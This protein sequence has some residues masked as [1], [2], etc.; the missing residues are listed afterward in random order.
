MDS[1]L[2]GKGGFMD[3]KLDM[4]K[5]YDQVEW[6]FLEAVMRKMGFAE[7]WIQLLMQCVK[8]VSYSILI[9]GQPH[10]SITPSRGIRQGD[11]LSP[12]LFIICTEAMSSLLQKEAMEGSITNVPI[13]RGGTSIH[14]IFFSLTIAYCFAELTLLNRGKFK[15]F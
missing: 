2:K 10:G 11:P 13:T 8:I 6:A 7:R 4:S 14:H 12:Y 15:P 5:A 9:N 1:R 3:L